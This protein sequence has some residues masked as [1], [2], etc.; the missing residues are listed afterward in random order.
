MTAM[1]VLHQDMTPDRLDRFR[2]AQDSDDDGFAEALHELRTTGKRSHWIWYIFPQ[3]AGLGSSSMARAFGLDGIAEATV[4]F[5]DPILRERLLDATAAVS[6]RL[7]QGMPLTRV[8]GSEIDSLKLVSS[9]TLFEAIAAK[10][11]PEHER[12]AK[13]AGHVLERA[14]A[15]GY[16]RCSFTSKALELDRQNK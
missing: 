16:P 7:D 14:E 9:L 11:G 12:L 8:M 2:L 13:L 1:V 3:L 10:A 15:Q 4:Y 5:R 6:E